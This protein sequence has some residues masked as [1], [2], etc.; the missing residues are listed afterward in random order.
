MGTDT[1]FQIA[2]SNCGCLSIKIE[3]PLKSSREAIVICGDCGTS[4]GTVGALRDLAVQRYP[5]VAGPTRPT[6]LSD[7]EHTS[8]GPGPVS[9]ISMRYA[10]FRRLRQQ[11]MVAEWLSNASNR[12]AVMKRARKKDARHLAF[13]PSLS[14]QGIPWVGDE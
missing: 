14:A 6:V 4:R 3:D 10:E 13:R 9:E 7:N 2:C 1:D 11:V 8:D 5:D 12:P